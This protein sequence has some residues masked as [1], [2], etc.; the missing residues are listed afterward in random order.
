[1]PEMAISVVVFA[2]ILVIGL[3]LLLVIYPR[4]LNAAVGAVNDFIRQLGCAICKMIPG[5]GWF[6]C[7]WKC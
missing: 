6:N 5:V 1:M 4:A 7:W 2:V 3:I